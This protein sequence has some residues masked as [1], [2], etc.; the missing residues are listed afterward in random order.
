M[1][2]GQIL[3]PLSVRITVLVLFKIHT[4]FFFTKE[5]NR[6]CIVWNLDENSD[7]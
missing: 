2:T 7:T 6:K 1:A 3:E 4:I 5:L